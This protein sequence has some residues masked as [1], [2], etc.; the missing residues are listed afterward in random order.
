[1]T[2]GVITPGPNTSNSHNKEWLNIHKS[3]DSLRLPRFRHASHIH[4][5]THT[6][7]LLRC[8]A[9]FLA[10]GAHNAARR[11]D[12]SHASPGLPRETH[13]TERHNARCPTPATRNARSATSKR[14]IHHTCHAKR[15]RSDVKV[16]DS[17]HLPRIHPGAPS[18]VPTRIRSPMPT[19]RNACPPSPS[20]HAANARGRSRTFGVHA[21][22]T[23]QI[24]SAPQTPTL[25]QEPFA[26]HSRKSTRP[27]IHQSGFGPLLTCAHSSTHSGFSQWFPPLAAVVHGCHEP[28]GCARVCVCRCGVF[29]TSPLYLQR[30]GDEEIRFGHSHRCYV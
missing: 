13:V 23:I 4:A 12:R 9:R 24:R 29:R 3:T 28:A 15:T 16:H 10:P 19:T 11:R 14:T 6:R 8:H 21:P 27:S 7:L 25:K 22:K 18:Q 5:R 1:M 2:Q 17:L 26:T 20:E 30:V